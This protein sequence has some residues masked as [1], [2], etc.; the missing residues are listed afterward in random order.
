MGDAAL[1]L[2][3][4][5]QPGSRWVFQHPARRALLRR[6]NGS[7]VAKLWACCLWGL[8]VLSLVGADAA[9]AASE[10][11]EAALQ[12]E[13]SRPVLELH[14]QGPE[15]LRLHVQGLAELYSSLDTA[16]GVSPEE[17]RAL[18][19]RIL[20]RVAQASLLLRAEGPG[21]N[22]TDKLQGDTV[23][24]AAL[25]PVGRVEGFFADRSLLLLGLLG[26]VIIAFSLGSL[27]GYRRG[28]RQAS[29]YGEGDPR[30][31]FIARSQGG[32]RPAGRPVRITQEQIR[33]ALMSGRTVLM[34]LGYE[35]APD[36]R[37]EFLNLLREMQ[38]ILNDVEGHAHS[39]WED[40]RH[41]NRFYELVICH[42]LD[43]L[44]LLTSGRSELAGLDAKIEAC[45]L[46]GRPVLRRA[47]W[48]VLPARGARPG[49]FGTREPAGQAPGDTSS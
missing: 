40:P 43:A 5:E 10:F 26:G 18:G 14:R 16:Q 3:R 28:A 7:D 12:R 6:P 41:P 37:G 46:P 33:K 19:D 44:D 49:H 1:H 11:D 24:P 45:W 4:F 30:R 32:A 35:I 17:R 13:L 23:R 8:L 20:A 2:D 25:I 38:G 22:R 31:L 21:P 9:P 36:R 34:Q 39:V 47:W 48:G 15:A 42:R 29:Y 27:T